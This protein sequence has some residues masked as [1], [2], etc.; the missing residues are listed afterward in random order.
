MTKANA[1]VRNVVMCTVI[2]MATA[3]TC[4]VVFRILEN[5]LF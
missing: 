3:L 1:E 5:I 4:G 2:L